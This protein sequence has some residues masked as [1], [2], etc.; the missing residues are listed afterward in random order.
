MHDHAG[1]VEHAAQAGCTS[2]AQLLVE[3]RRQVSRLGAGA[4]LLARAVEHGP[5]RRNRERIVEVARE[6]VD[7]REIA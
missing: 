5:R 6:L 1:R 4:D 7:R 3:A 2:C